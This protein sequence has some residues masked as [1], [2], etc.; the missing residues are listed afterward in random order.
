MK[1]KVTGEEKLVDV[2]PDSK[3][4]RELQMKEI[5]NRTLATASFLENFTINLVVILK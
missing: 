5:G 2:K 4:I 3:E 1:D